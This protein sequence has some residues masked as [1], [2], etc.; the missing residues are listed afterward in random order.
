MGEWSEAIQDGVICSKCFLPVITEE[1]IP[2]GTPVIC[3][4]CR[5][6]K[7]TSTIGSDWLPPR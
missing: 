1:G 3:E 4:Q 7:D 5:G 2:L 6:N